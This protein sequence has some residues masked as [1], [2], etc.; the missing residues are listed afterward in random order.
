MGLSVRPPES[1]VQRHVFGIV[2]IPYG[3]LEY[4]A[5]D[6]FDDRLGKAL[7]DVAQ[8]LGVDGKASVSLLDEHGITEW[9]SEV[10]SRGLQ[11]GVMP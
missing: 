8:L 1:F 10:V 11:E 9:I 7:K 6:D 5:R 4:E 3:E 2:A